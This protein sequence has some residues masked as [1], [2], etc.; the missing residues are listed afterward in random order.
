[1]ADVSWREAASLC[2]AA[3]GLSPAYEF[4]ELPVQYDEAVYGGYRVMRGGGWYDEPWSVRAGVRRR[5][6][7]DTRIGDVEF[8]LASSLTHSGRHEPAEFHVNV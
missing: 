1:M 7:P 4:L 3:D 5:S 2:N 8:R 6:S